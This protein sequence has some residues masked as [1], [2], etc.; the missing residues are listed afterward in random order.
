[1][2]TS[3]AAVK[4]SQYPSEEDL[5][6]PRKQA[7]YLYKFHANPLTDSEKLAIPFLPEL[8]R[9]VPYPNYNMG[10]G[11]MK[12]T[13]ELHLFLRIIG[14]PGCGKTRMLLEFRKSSKIEAHY[15]GVPKHSDDKD[16]LLLM[17]SAMGY[18]PT[19]DTCTLQ[20]EIVAHINNQARPIVFLIDEIDNLCPKYVRKGTTNIDKLDVIRFIWDHTRRYSSFSQSSHRV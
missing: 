17:S 12:D 4:R 11:L 10:L 16:L 20:Q 9:L 18:Y 7:G 14:D 19:G 13:A 1:M 3:D 2:E 8:F 5:S 15:I 6:D